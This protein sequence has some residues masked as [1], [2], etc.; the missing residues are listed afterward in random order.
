MGEGTMDF[1]N[2][3]S[4]HCSPMARR[5]M[6]VEGVATVFYGPDFISISKAEDTEWQYIKPS[7]FGIITDF[8]NKDEPLF[9]DSPE[10]ED[11]KITEEDSECVQAIKEILDSRIRPVV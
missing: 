9:T 3:R 10:P 4:T 11:T 6:T 8:Y 7:I 2:L 5:L 1:V